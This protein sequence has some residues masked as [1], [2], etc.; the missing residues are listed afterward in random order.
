VP[1]SIGS[2]RRPRLNR[3]QSTWDR[4]GSENPMSAVLTSTEQWEEGEFFATGE[5]EVAEVMSYLMALRPEMP[6]GSA[7]D[8]GCG[9]GRVS[10]ALSFHFDEVLGVDIA[11]SMVRAARD[12]HADRP[13][14]RFMVNADPDLAG[15]DSGSFDLVYSN[16]TLQHAPPRSARAYISEFVRVVSPSGVILF[17]LP[18]GPITGRGRLATGLT[19]LR[20][21]GAGEGVRR[22]VRRGRP[23]MLMH[24]VDRERVVKLL[25]SSGAQVLDVREDSRAGPQWAGFRYAAIKQIS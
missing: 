24:G 8:F 17:Q 3:L 14:C 10:R 21:S 4:L 16:I 7:L 25:E 5:E 15:L 20:Y 13:N 23:R 1:H 2:V 18:T 9:P 6:T 11:P 19:R 22:L 12:L